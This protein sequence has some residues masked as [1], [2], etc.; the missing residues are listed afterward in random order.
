[1]DESCDI[2]NRRSRRSNVLLAASI[3]AGG[4]TIGVKLRN[5]SPDGALIEAESL[6]AEG[7]EVRFRRNDIHVLGRIAWVVG[8]HAGVAFAEALDPSEVMRNIPAPKAKPKLDFRR[9]GLASR[10]LTPEERQLIRQ[11]G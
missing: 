7:A 5:L 3:E 2:A 9:P 1:M 6:P 8:R 4:S 10:P 11:W